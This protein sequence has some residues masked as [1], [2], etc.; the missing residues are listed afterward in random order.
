MI[1][2][3][4]YFAALAA[5]LFFIYLKVSIA[6]RKKQLVLETLDV[7]SHYGNVERS[8]ESIRFTTKRACYDVTFFHVPHGAELTVN[9]KTVWEIEQYGRSKL[10]K[11]DLTGEQKRV[12]ILYPA[13]TRPKRYINENEMVFVRSDEP[14][15]NTY[16]VN[17]NELETVLKKD[18]F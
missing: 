5:V 1:I 15:Y 11:Q 12:I 7:L 13:D 10:I 18:I 9:S 17:R 16:L 6:K 4:L 3:S 2:E 14:F 8:A